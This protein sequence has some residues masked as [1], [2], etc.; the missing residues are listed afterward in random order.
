[1]RAEVEIKKEIVVGVNKLLDNYT[2]LF[3]HEINHTELEHHNDAM[4]WLIIMKER[5]QGH[6]K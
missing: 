1:M 2:D 4:D 6:E 5:M 3:G